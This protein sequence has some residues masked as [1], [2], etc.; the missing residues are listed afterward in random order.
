MLV[1]RRWLSAGIAFGLTASAGALDSAQGTATVAPAATEELIA[2]KDAGAPAD[3]QEDMAS[4]DGRRVA[5]RTHTGK[6]WTVMLNGN[7]QAAEFDEVRSFTFS[8]DGQHLAFAARR[9]NTWLVVID[10]KESALRFDEVGRPMFDK[11]GARVAYAAKRDKK[12]TVVI[13]SEASAASYDDVGTPVFSDDGGHLTY[14][15]KRAGKWSVIVDG[16]ERGPQFDDISARIFS[17]DGKRV[18]YAGHRAGKWMGVLDGKEGPPFDILGGLAFSSDSRRF[19]YA[20]ADVH[21][22][23]GS[24]RA[25]GRTILDGEPGPQFEGNQVGSFKK[26][27]VTGTSTV[28]IEGFFSQLL[29]DIHG[30]TAPVFS[31]DGA[32]VAHAVRRG[33][34]DATVMVDGQPGPRFPSI[35]AGPV[36][37][38][39]SR[40]VAYVVSDAGVKTLVVDGERVGGGS[41]PGTDFVSELTFAPDNRTVGY[42]GITGGSWYESGFTRRARRRV[43]VDGRSGVEYR[44]G[45]CH[46]ATVHLRRPS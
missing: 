33:E 4:R 18:A 16:E 22:S 29:S 13:G 41:A 38:A 20:G 11:D 14:P 40:H 7:P 21:R 42:V 3:D 26:S 27:M 37:S 34:D 9:D 25:Q 12:W 2:E 46:E 15:A 28:I 30:V 43:Y 8:R 17:P 24:Q 35:V 5:W 1:P 23:L 6:K 45:A 19:A 10:A 39:D 31:P 36:F 44:R 32:R